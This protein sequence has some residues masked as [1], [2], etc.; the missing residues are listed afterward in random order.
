MSPRHLCAWPVV[1]TSLHQKMSSRS[2]YVLGHMPT[3][4]ACRDKWSPFADESL[5]HNYAIRS[6]D[7]QRPLSHAEWCAPL[8]TVQSGNSRSDIQAT[9]EGPPRK[10]RASSNT[11][12]AD[13]LSTY[14]GTPGHRRMTQTFENNAGQSMCPSLRRPHSIAEVGRQGPPPYNHNEPKAHHIRA[15]GGAARA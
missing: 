7:N 13:R 6:L 14:Q 9:C 3:N 11:C 8:W 5:E 10:H 12:A 1:R 2:H 15:A 4:H